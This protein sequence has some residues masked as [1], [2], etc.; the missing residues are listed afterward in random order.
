MKKPDHD[1]E[2]LSEMT[3]SR[4]RFCKNAA[5]ASG[6]ALLPAY[7]PTHGAVGR[8]V[9]STH[10]ISGMSD[11]VSKSIVGL[12]G[13]WL[14]QSR[15]NPGKYSFRHS[16]YTD[17]EEW[18]QKIVPLVKEYLARPE[19]DYTP[20]P[21]IT[22]S[23]QY[24][25]LDIEELEWTL[26]Y[27]HPTRAVLLKPAEA[28][29]S[30]PGILG[31][32]DHGGNKFFGLRKITRTGRDQHP[33]M[34]EHQEYYYE[35]RAWANEIA[36]RGYVVLVHD[37]FTFASRRVRYEEVSEIPW[38]E[39]STTDKSDANPELQENI[40]TYNSWASAHEHVM[41]KS[42][43]CGGTTWP[44]MFLL[45]DQIALSVLAAREEVDQDRIGCAGLSGG[46]LRTDFLGGL[47]ERIKCAVS[48]GFMSTWDDFMLNKSYTHTWMT[49][50]P[51]LP[52]FL[53]FPE[54]FGLR[55]PLPTMV[56]STTEDQLYT[57]PEMKKA[58]EILE[59]NYAKAGASEA[60]SCKFYPGTHKFDATMQRDAF[61]WMD[62]WL[63]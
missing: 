34:E 37:V 53:E 51:I 46:G 61:E 16:Q 7:V 21:R 39:V 22:R 11:N 4:R 19:L 35:G 26:P 15:Q 45:E 12:Y 38:G 2:D 31:L 44:G 63:K 36:K 48:V 62:R 29:G 6:V 27:G 17:V 32:H 5:L 23:Y 13:P 33:M 41:A 8:G 14:A 55:M 28:S 47:D 42:L 52:A 56:Q 60:L 9:S 25:G 54:I 18:Q 58:A 1:K 20:S 30:L 50:V 3:R 57:L 24:D 43:F 40:D 49:Y 10:Q 59:D